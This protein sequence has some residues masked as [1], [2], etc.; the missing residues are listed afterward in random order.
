M[1][2]AKKGDTVKVHYTGTL[3]D[4]TVFDSS[5]ER[6]PLKFMI[7]E[8]SVIPSFEEVVVGMNPGESKTERIAA[9]E[10]YGPHHKEMV[11]E[12]E[13]KLFPP[14]MKPEVGQTVQIPRKDG[15]TMN[16]TIT[17]V[18]EEKVT[19]DANHPLAGKDL[20]FEIKLLE[21]E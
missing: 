15:K 4:G 6:E 20:I 1:P 14:N 9:D 10:A 2:H 7:G 18:S 8:G 5:L 19:L 11:M 13:K 21:V 12:V 16:V 3:E 17:G